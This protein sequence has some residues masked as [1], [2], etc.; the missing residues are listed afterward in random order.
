[1]RSRRCRLQQIRIIGQALGP[2]NLR[3]NSLNGLDCA[4]Q[5]AVF[6]RHA[7]FDAQRTAEHALDAADQL[8]LRGLLNHGRIEQDT[9]SG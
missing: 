2:T 8:L 3:G 5:N 7:W 6:M 4:K 9:H 1:M